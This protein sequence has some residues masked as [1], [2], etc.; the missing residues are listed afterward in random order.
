MQRIF[1]FLTSKR[2][3]PVLESKSAYAQWAQH[4][5][6]QAH[7]PLM[8]AEEA[9]M[10]NLMPSLAGKRVLDLACGTGR[11]GRWSQAQAAASVVAVD[12]SWPML[13]QADLPARVLAEMDSL[14][15]A[16]QSIDVVICALALGHLS[17]RRFMLSMR[18]IARV[19]KPGAFALISDFHPFLAWQGA[20]RTFQ[21]DDGRTYAVEHYLHSY[22]DYWKA[23]QAASLS[24]DA[25]Q[26]AIH[27]DQ[28]GK[29][30]PLVLL[31][32]LTKA[33]VPSHNQNTSNS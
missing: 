16:V 14:P 13:R 27:P 9:A 22:A 18:E 5:P 10:K 31:L 15:L 3:T 26:E 11:W 20:Q 1:R 17:H 28:Q 33:P 19:M 8:Q 12:N 23:A 2:H 7:N 6:A 29:N 25:V 24:I 30:M 32:R 21:G 4:Y